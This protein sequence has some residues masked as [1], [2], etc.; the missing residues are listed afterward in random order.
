M[1]SSIGPLKCGVVGVTAT[2]K[3]Q[4]PTVPTG[5]SGVALSG[6]APLFQSKGGM[7]LPSLLLAFWGLHR[8]LHRGGQPHDKKTCCF[9]HHVVCQAVSGR[10]LVLPETVADPD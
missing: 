10:P 1:S 5:T 8:G 6:A 4:L 9:P 2:V 7:P 3:G